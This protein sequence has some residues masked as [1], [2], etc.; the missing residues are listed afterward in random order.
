MNP[1]FAA[2]VVA[3][4]GQ[5]VRPGICLYGASPFADRSAADMGL[6][7][8]MTLSA[9]LI[10]T[11][12]VPAGAQVGYGYRYTA[13]C[14]MKVGVVACGYADGYPRHAPDGTPVTAA[15]VRPQLI[16]RVS[17]DIMAVDFSLVPSSPVGGPVVLTSKGRRE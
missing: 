12:M 8:A 3:P 11:R 4:D 13:R 5:W 17:M 1:G 7:P 6:L 15:G 2:Q 14:A 9:R 10:S 16:V